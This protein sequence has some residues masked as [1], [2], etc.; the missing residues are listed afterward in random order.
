MRRDRGWLEDAFLFVCDVL[1]LPWCPSRKPVGIF[2]SIKPDSEQSDDI[3]V[4]TT[5]LMPIALL[6]SQLSF[7][8]SALPQTVVTNIYRSIASRL[9]EHIFHR[10]ILY[11]GRHR[12]TLA[13]GKNIVAECELWMETCQAAL[14]GSSN[15]ARVEAPWSRLLEGARL[16]A[17]EGEVWD[18]LV[19]GT[20]GTGDDEE[21]EAL[22]EEMVGICE[23]SREH[24]AQVL[25]S[26]VDC[27]R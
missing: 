1:V 9:S 18:N 21:W 14:S 25:Q 8:R 6:S 24:V 11:G 27:G 20:F 10:Q 7:L 4:S 26:R 19:D 5:L 15:R 22:V 17:A 2:C 13:E 23:I 16:V 12:L 3:T